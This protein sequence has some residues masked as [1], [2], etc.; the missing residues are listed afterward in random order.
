KRVAIAAGDCLVWQGFASVVIP[1]F[2]INR[3]CTFT[4]IAL[5]KGT[6]LGGPVRHWTTTIIGLMFIPFIIK[7]IDHSVEIGMDKTI[8]KLYPI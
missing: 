6:Q 2:I 1:G 8:R 7:P 5:K 3:I 4:G